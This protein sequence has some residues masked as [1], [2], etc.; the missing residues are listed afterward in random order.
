MKKYLF[1]LLL[2]TTFV[3][4]CKDDDPEPAPEH[5]TPSIR[6]QVTGTV[7]DE[8]GNPLK[9]IAVRLKDNFMN[10]A[11]KDPYMQLDSV[12]TDEKGEYIT[13]FVNDTGIRDGLVL[14]AEDTDGLENGGLF[15]PDT[16][17]LTDMEKKK[18]GEGADEWDSGTWQLKADFKLK[19]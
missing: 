17:R 4:S 1:F 3:V 19:K 11:F 10:P 12:G 5:G 7:T 18:V 6:Y 9:G 16:I 14:I 8:A 13:N 2:S 15:R